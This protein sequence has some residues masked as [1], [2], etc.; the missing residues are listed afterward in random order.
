MKLIA[1]ILKGIAVFLFE[2]KGGKRKGLMEKYR[3]KLEDLLLNNIL[4]LK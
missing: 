4:I 2:L 3:K 1:V